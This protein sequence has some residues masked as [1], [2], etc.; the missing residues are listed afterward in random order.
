MLPFSDV[1]NLLPCSGRA[2]SLSP[3]LHWFLLAAPSL[4]SVQGPHDACIHQFSWPCSVST[5]A[6]ESGCS[7]WPKYPTSS[8]RGEIS[9]ILPCICS[10]CSCA[11]GEH[12]QCGILLVNENGAHEQP[13]LLSTSDWPSILITSCLTTQ[14]ETLNNGLF[15]GSS[16]CFC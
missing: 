14:E 1:T 13:L 15:S 2:L 4:V 11:P 3:L 6:A 16:W 12:E 5:C 8:P 10:G 9:K 7:C